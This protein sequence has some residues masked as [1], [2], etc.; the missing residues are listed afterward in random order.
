MTTID[1]ELKSELSAV[2]EGQGCE[3]LEAKLESGV[4]RL[5][6]DRLDG[7]VTVDTCAV[8]SRQVSALLDVMDFGCA[9]Y[10]LEV[11]SPGLDRPLSGPA[12]YERFVGRL[13]KI[14]FSEAG[15]DARRTVVGRLQAFDAEGEVVTVADSQTNEPIGID[16]ARIVRAR[17]E[18]EL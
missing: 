13:A 1:Q 17:L 2:A 6:L 7:A 18:I 5:V 10:T 16:Q 15:S 4:L 14:T 12:D 8:V 11:S 9:R 3:L